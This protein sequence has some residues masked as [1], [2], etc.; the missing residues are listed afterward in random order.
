MIAKRVMR[1]KAGAFRRLGL[2]ILDPEK[3]AGPKLP[4]ISEWRR[5]AEYILDLA[6]SGTR[7][8]GVRITNCRSTDVDL[9]IREIEATQKCN[10]RAKGDKTYHLVVSFPPG[11][12]PTPAQLLDIEE[13]LCR[14]IG[15]HKH[16]RISAVHTDTAHLH[17]HVAINQVHPETF[18]CIEPWYDKRKLMA[19]CDRLEIKHGLQR[20]RHHGGERQA[21][22]GKAANMEAHGGASLIGRIKRD[23]LPSV[24]ELLQDGGGWQALHVAWAAHGLAIRLRGAGLIIADAQ[25]WLAV[26][27]SSA[28]RRLSLKSLTRRWGAFQPPDDGV[29][30]TLGKVQPPGAPRRNGKSAGKSPTSRRRGPAQAQGQAGSEVDASAA[31][32]DARRRE[33][34]K[35]RSNE[36]TAVICTRPDLA[37]E[38]RQRDYAAHD[39]EKAVLRDDPN[40]EFREQGQGA[41]GRRTSATGHVAPGDA[42][43]HTEDAHVPPLAGTEWRITRRTVVIRLAKARYGHAPI[44]WRFQVHRAGDGAPIFDHGEHIRVPR[45]TQP[46]I[47]LAL[48]ILSERFPSEQFALSGPEAFIRRTIEIATREYPYI[49]HLINR[50]Y[51]KYFFIFYR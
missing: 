38:G 25:G 32:A 48:A 11:E 18:A 7:A 24:E 45:A 39:T 15:L 28:D 40:A 36:A 51:T 41:N 21:A 1:G 10:R 29:Q 2:Y 46:A 5:T 43:H 44:P 19:A 23:V 42:N 27:A 17:M 20:T 47:V 50:K 12:R 22:P 14:A 26:K 30:S 8:E 6:A 33:M 16:Q 4:A 49:I 37:A 35:S 34:P 3:L 13:E 31:H 9:A